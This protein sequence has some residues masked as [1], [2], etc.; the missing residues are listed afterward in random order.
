MGKPIISTT[1]AGFPDMLV[2]RVIRLKNLIGPNYADV[3]TKKWAR[4]HLAM[5]GIS[6][7]NLGDPYYEG[8]WNSVARNSPNIV[9]QMSEV[10]RQWA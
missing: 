3:D 10:L 5:S 6:V 9:Q 4:E 7:V 8:R 2:D 1:F